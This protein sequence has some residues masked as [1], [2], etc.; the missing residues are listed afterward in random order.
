[1]K[2]VTLPEEA[3]RSLFG[4]YDENIKYLEG[5]VGVRVNLRGNE[6]NIEGAIYMPKTH[7]WI[8]GN[9]TLASSCLQIVSQRITFKGNMN[10]TNSCTSRPGQMMELGTVRLVG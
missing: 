2:K 9:S 3:I 6:L 5:L 8:N 7:L 4:P 10:L 1:L